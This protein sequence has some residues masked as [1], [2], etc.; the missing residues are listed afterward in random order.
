MPFPL[1]NK[2]PFFFEIVINRTPEPVARED[3][4]PQMSHSFVVRFVQDDTPSA[5]WTQ[6]PEWGS[7][8]FRS[9][10]T[11]RF[12]VSDGFGHFEDT[13]N[14]VE[15]NGEKNLLQGLKAI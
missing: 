2:L 12:T 4:E 13:R 1:H 5:V 10:K 15:G 6:F 9:E 11:E 3:S 8:A 14:W 7:C